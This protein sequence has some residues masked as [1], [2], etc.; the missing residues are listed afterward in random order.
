VR[1]FV[2]TATYELRVSRKKHLRDHPKFNL[3][4]L[5]RTSPQRNRLRKKA[6]AKNLVATIITTFKKDQ[7]T[8]L[9]KQIQ[10]V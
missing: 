4:I 1:I 9:T 10:I 3:Y 2:L 5:Q 6:I 8:L 7:E